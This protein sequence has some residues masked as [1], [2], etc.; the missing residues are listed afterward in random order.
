MRELKHL[1]ENNKKWAEAARKKNPDVF[2]KMSEGQSP[3]YLWI[4]CSDSRI[5]A[6]EILGMEPGHVVVHR[7]IANLFPHTDFNCLSV[8][9]YA[10]NYLHVEHVIV[11]GHYGCGGVRAAYQGDHLG[12][13]DNW[14]GHV[15]DVARKHQA[16]IG[17]IPDLRDR[18]NRLCE[19]NVEDQV[20]NVCHTTVLRDAWARGQQVT[21]HGWIYGL[22]D[23]LLHDLDVGGSTAEEFEA[24]WRERADAYLKA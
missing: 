3:K 16:M 18:L 17:K 5:P 19:L 12:L 4:G 7:N 13:V 1:F 23:G 6:N 24:G 9:E 10:V 8:L 20:A 21:V 2:I 15:Q 14:L 11:C 22:T